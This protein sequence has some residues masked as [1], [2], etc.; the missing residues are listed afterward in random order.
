MIS[1][2]LFHCEDEASRS[3]SSAKDCISKA[4]NVPQVPTTGER[5]KKAPDR[6]YARAR[7]LARQRW[8]ASLG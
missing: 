5:R 3:S 8:Q 1:L 6:L 4:P 2:Q 7:A